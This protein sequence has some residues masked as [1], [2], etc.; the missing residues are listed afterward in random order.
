M[1][2]FLHRKPI[3]QAKMM[4]LAAE[5]MKIDFEYKIV[6]KVHVYCGVGKAFRPYKCLATVQSEDNQTVY[7]KMCQGSEAIDETRNGLEHVRDQNTKAVCVIYV[8]NCCS[9]R[10]KLLSIFPDACVKL[11]PLHYMKR[12][13]AVLFDANSEEAAIFRGRMRRAMF[14]VDNEEFQCV[15]VSITSRL[16]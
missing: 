14:V 13:D 4:G 5:V 7:Y 15:K 16:S 3:Q 2:D 1:T 8:D 12:W 11:D 9:V 6:K 10:Q